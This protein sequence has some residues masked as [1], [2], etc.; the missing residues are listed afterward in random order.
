MTDVNDKT[1]PVIWDK[2]TDFYDGLSS[3]LL[4]FYCCLFCFIYICTGRNV[5]YTFILF[6]IIF[7]LYSLYNNKLN[8]NVTYKKTVI[9]PKSKYIEKNNNFA[10]IVFSIQEFYDYNPQLYIN[11]IKSI[12]VFLSIYE[13]IK[14]DNA[15]AGQLYNSLEKQKFM[16]LDYIQGIII[17][18]PDNRKVIEKINESI[19]QLEI[20]M[21]RYIYDTYKM[22][23]EYIIKNGYNIETKLIYHDMHQPYNE[24]FNVNL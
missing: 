3:K 5:L 1:D 9:F 11:A 6:I 19:H 17:E 18:S 23:K 2:L 13:Y 20:L 21:N 15:L 24:T 16:T 14:I 10:D 4:F 22:N 12:D 8:N 7:T